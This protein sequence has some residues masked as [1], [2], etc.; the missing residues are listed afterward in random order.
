LVS[1]QQEEGGGRREEEGG[2]SG[3]LCAVGPHIGTVGEIE[4]GRHYT[5]ARC[6]GGEHLVGTW[7]AAEAP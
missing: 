7:Q 4:E 3:D 5:D 2:R 6:V 1:Q